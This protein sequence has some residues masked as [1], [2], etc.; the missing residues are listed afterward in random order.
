MRVQFLGFGVEGLPPD[1]AER[2]N[3]TRI[4]G[5][6]P[7]R[8][9]STAARLNL[10]RAAVE[11]RL[12][13][14]S[15]SRGYRR[16][17]A[18]DF[19]AAQ[20]PSF[21]ASQMR[22]NDPKG[23]AVNPTTADTVITRSDPQ[24]HP[25]RTP[26]SR[27]LVRGRHPLHRKKISS[28]KPD[29]DAKPPRSGT[30]PSL[31]AHVPSIATAVSKGRRTLRREEA[32]QRLYDFPSKT[33]AIRDLARRRRHQARRIKPSKIRNLK[34]RGWERSD[35]RFADDGFWQINL[36]TGCTERC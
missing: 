9:T 35:L 12:C 3:T 13:A 10:A 8:P 36:P 32:V 22:P 25:S 26:Y 5:R 19:F 6:S 23:L 31:Q 17:P 11:A 29:G 20:L 16:S 34:W 30:I 4:H 15:S 18:N 27:H 21:P 28:Q 7:R 1:D 33:C 2:L 14:L 24:T